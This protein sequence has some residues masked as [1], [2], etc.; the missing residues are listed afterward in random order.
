MIRTGASI[1]AILVVLISSA[2]IR[3]SGI[4]VDAGLTP[5][6]GRWII[7]TQLRYIPS[8]M[9]GNMSENQMRMYGVPVMLAYG[10][11]NYLMVMARETYMSRN[12]T[13]MGMES[14]ESGIGDLYLLAKYKAVRINDRRHTVGIS[15]TIGISV[16]TGKSGLSSDSWDL[17]TGL[18]FSGRKGRWAT[19]LNLGYR[20]N[21][22][23]GDLGSDTKPG[24]E[25]TV[26][27]AGAYQHSLNPE[28]AI[29][30]V[31]EFNFSQLSRD[32]TSGSENP[33]S[34]GYILYLSP[35]AKFTK[36]STIFEVLLKIPVSR[37]YNG[38]QMEAGTGFIAGLRI[39]I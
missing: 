22:I 27:W 36:S 13:M 1:A 32:E 28:T 12:M 23:A 7:R 17:T 25:M 6:E 37:H 3:A 10:L 26:D 38:N 5:P 15:P 8:E 35:G 2:S 14:S 30:P 24:N 34:G 33:D 11:K 20:W 9:T 29:A 19:D 4:S 18:Y 16:P 31:M 39:M 21:D